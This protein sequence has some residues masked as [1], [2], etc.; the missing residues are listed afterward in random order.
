MNKL[1]LSII[2]LISTCSH[3]SAQQK[4]HREIWLFTPDAA[5]AS[6]ISQKSALMDTAGLKERDLQIHEVVG[7]EQNRAVFGKYKASAQKFTFVLVGKDSGVKL[8]S[9]EVVGRQKLYHTID[10]MP[11]RKSEMKQP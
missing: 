10:A 3:S 6:F 11:M 5:N 7:Y 8:R 9:N 4:N 1:F 2:I